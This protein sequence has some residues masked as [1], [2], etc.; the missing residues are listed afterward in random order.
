MQCSEGHEERALWGR[1]ISGRQV[2][3]GQNGPCT[4]RARQVTPVGSDGLM[5]F[6]QLTQIATLLAS[7][8]KRSP[9]DWTIVMVT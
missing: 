4:R 2:N 1:S 8:L 7:V 3:R 6:C 9:L 5:C